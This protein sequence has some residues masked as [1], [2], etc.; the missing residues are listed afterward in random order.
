MA[1]ET[2][3]VSPAGQSSRG[4]TFN[5]PRSAAGSYSV[6]IEDLAGSFTVTAKAGAEPVSELLVKEIP[7]AAPSEEPTTT[8]VPLTIAIAA[9]AVALGAI[10]VVL[11]RKKPR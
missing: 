8:S 3:T 9:G 2:K 4:V 11:F 1:L 5:V 10:L 7:P 6:S